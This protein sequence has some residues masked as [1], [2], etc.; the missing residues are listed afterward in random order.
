MD[1]NTPNGLALSPPHNNQDNALQT[2]PQ[3]SL[4]NG[5]NSSVEVSKDCIGSG[6]IARA[7]GLE[8]YLQFGNQEEGGFFG[9][10]L[11]FKFLRQ[12]CGAQFDLYLVC[13]PCLLHLEYD[14]LALVLQVCM[15]MLGLFLLLGNGFKMK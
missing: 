2:C 1:G 13:S 11:I 12:G 10:N 7:E 15:A 6:S 4:S 14:F 8:V 9:F 5:G 3:A